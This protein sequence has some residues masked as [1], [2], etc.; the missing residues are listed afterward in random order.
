MLQFPHAPSE[1]ERSVS[2]IEQKN[3]SVERTLRTLYRKGD[4]IEVRVWDKQ[5]EVYTGRYHRNRA[6]ITALKLFNEAGCDCYLVL[7]PVGDRR[8]LREISRGGLCTW[9]HEVPHRRWFLLD[10]DPKREGKIATDEQW[11]AAKEMATQAKRWLESK[12][13]TG[14]ILASSGNGCHLLLPCDL[15]NDAPSKESVRKTQRIVANRF[16]N[17]AVECECFPDANRLVRAYGTLNRKGDETDQLKHRPSRIIEVGTEGECVPKDIMAKL[18]ADNPLPET[19]ANVHAESEGE[20]P[21]TRDSLFERLQAWAEGW[22]GRN[23][24][25]FHFE[26]TDRK[27]GFRIWCPGNFP[28]GW[29]DGEAHTDSYTSLNDSSIVWV[30]NGWP[31]F[32]CG[33][34]HCDAGAAHGKKTWADL[35]NYY[36]P[37]RKLH[38]VMSEFG[39]TRWELEFVD[40][41][42]KAESA[43]KEQ[44]EAVLGAE[45]KLQETPEQPQP[46][47]KKLHAMPECAMY[48]WC[49]EKA[50]ELETPLG[51]AYP[52]IVTAV[53]AMI[54]G[55]T[56]GI[57]PTMYTVLIGPVH[58]GKTETIKR[59]IDSL[60][61]PD[62]A[63]V[64]WTVPGSDRGLINIFGGKKKDDKDKDPVSNARF[65]KT[66]LL[67]QDEFR[68]TI[69]KSNI[70]GSSL[71]PTLCSLWSQDEAGAADKTGEHICLVKLNILGGLKADDPEEF[72]EVFGKESTAGLYDRCVYGIAPKGWKW[73]PWEP[74]PA[75]RMPSNPAITPECYQMLARWRD[76]NPVSRGR[77]GEIALRIAYITAAANHDKT[78]S[79][80]CMRCALEFAEW[81]E[82][83]RA[84][85][86]PGMGDAID[87][88]ATNAI[89][90]VLE[91]LD[92]KWVSWRELSTKK[93]WYRKYGASTLRRVREALQATGVTVEET[94][95]LDNGKQQRTG[96]IRLR[97]REDD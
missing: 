52:A 94:I 81:Q 7:N 53:A 50:R 11:E 29:P 17:A 66:H 67:A 89:L 20:G 76:T 68:N 9:E 73:Q 64:K 96:Q 31:R 27:D 85:Y 86:R 14:I 54:N 10:F 55:T 46:E 42:V 6:L 91:Q 1:L 63:T 51:Y 97:R 65:A 61:W 78:I 13:W 59:A 80:E 56:R 33:H 70:S 93:N 22:K 21:F 19:S 41:G 39:D 26:E 24:E 88:Q 47:R 8:G 36:D 5:H 16:S 69:N 4:I 57:R 77:L 12:G 62:P 79:T 72:A 23:G 30:E 40:D 44:V 15:P 90:M 92:G 48:G 82:S 38:R 84:G 75:P 74:K 28:D 43:T 32:R 25:R 2:N 49:A 87:A 37:A 60:L 34:N 3:S 18:I 95:D 35:Q 71:A 58:C 45:V 83:I